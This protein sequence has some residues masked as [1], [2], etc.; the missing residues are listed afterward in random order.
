MCQKRGLKAF[1]NSLATSGSTACSLE[2]ERAASFVG[3]FLSPKRSGPFLRNAVA[4]GKLTLPNKP[5]TAVS[6]TAVVITPAGF[7]LNSSDALC[8]GWAHMRSGGAGSSPSSLG[9]ILLLPLGGLGLGGFQVALP[10][11]RRGDWRACAEVS[12]RVSGLFS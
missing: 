4:C 9:G 12:S 10:Q 5:L 2:R 11:P 7:L 3:W 6:P 8:Q 1:V